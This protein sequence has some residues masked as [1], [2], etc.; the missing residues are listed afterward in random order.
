MLM[1]MRG[2][3]QLYYGDEILMAGES[4]PDG[5]VRSDFE[6]GWAEDK[7]NKFTADGRSEKENEAFNYVRA[8]A[9]Y[10]K[11]STALQM[12]KMM[13]YIPQKDIYVYF[14]YDAGSTVMVIYNSSD[15]DATLNTDRFTERMAGFAQA[16]N[17][18]TG[19]QLPGIKHISV[20]GKSTLVLELSK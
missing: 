11:S 20:S 2:I 4:K 12:G 5:L 1:T 6:G 7:L 13:Q 16:K 10:R 19:E 15:K 8:L 3:P 17:I 18:I 9:N 14:R